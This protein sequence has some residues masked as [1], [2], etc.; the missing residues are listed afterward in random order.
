[1]WEL[2]VFQ[3]QLEWLWTTDVRFAIKVLPLLIWWSFIHFTVPRQVTKRTYFWESSSY[4]PA[5]MSRTSTC[6][7][8]ACVPSNRN[9]QYNGFPLCSCPMLLNFSV[10]GLSSDTSDF[11]ECFIVWLQSSVKRKKIHGK[12]F[13]PK[14]N[15]KWN[16]NNTWEV[17]STKGPVY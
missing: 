6:I 7:D 4:I 1:M 2:P 15:I 14:K 10:R 8:C 3:S 13:S 12:L 11:M 9:Q 16:R 17:A 5:L